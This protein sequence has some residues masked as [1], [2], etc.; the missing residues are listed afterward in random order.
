M[1]REVKFSDQVAAGGYAR[2]DSSMS[3]RSGESNMSRTK[4]GSP[5][6][7]ARD[8]IDRIKWTDRMELRPYVQKIRDFKDRENVDLL[9][10]GY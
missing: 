1:L 10:Q 6:G 9:G 2:A 5:R 3:G 4:R 7:S 8:T